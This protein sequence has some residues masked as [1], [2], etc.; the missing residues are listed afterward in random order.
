MNREVWLRTRQSF[1]QVQVSTTVTGGA[2]VRISQ[3]T[4]TLLY[5]PA[6][7][8]QSTLTIAL[9]IP[10]YDG[11]EVTITSGGTQTSGTA[12]TTLT[13]SATDKQG[14]SLTPIGTALTA[15]VIGTV[16]KYQWSEAANNW[17]RLQ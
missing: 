3:N 11:Q 1:N 8:P 17:Y 9:P 16:A 15:L 2:T 14:N 13:L 10:T 6:T 5:N 7:I 4:S 12:V